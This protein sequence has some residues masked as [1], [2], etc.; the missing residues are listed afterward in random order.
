M[1]RIFLFISLVIVC[2]VFFSERIFSVFYS[3]LSAIEDVREKIKLEKSTY[4]KN[5]VTNRLLFSNASLNDVTVNSDI[6]NILSIGKPSNNDYSETDEYMYFPSGIEYLLGDEVVLAFKCIFN[7]RWG[8]GYEPCILNLIFDGKEYEIDKTT[9]EDDII[10]IIGKPDD[11][12][13]NDRYKILYYFFDDFFYEID[14]KMD[15]RISYI[16]GYSRK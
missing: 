6:L 16:H 7:D 12:E 8:L 10:K 2:S 11:F 4:S 5:N 15:G 13:M 3:E 9:K 1:K 14:I